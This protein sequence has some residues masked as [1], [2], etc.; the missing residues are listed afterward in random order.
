MK[1]LGCPKIQ[2]TSPYDAQNSQHAYTFNLSE[3]FSKLRSN[4]ILEVHNSYPT[5]VTELQSHVR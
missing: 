3:I 2:N 1:I 5:H 4:N